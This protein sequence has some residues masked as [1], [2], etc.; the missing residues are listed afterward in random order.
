MWKT[1]LDIHIQNTNLQLREHVCQW[2][3]LYRYSSWAAC[4]SIHDVYGHI[5]EISYDDAIMSPSL[6]REKSSV[7]RVI[8]DHTY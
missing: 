1:I 7:V 5:S 8:I 2:S 3:D 6:E 4:W